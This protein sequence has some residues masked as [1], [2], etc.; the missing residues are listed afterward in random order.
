MHRDRGTAAVA[1]AGWT[2]WN[3]L[4]AAAGK[5][6]CAYAVLVRGRGTDGRD[7]TGSRWCLYTPAALGQAAQGRAAKGKPG[8]NIVSRTELTERRSSSVGAGL[9]SSCLESH[10]VESCKAKPRCWD[11]ENDQV[12][13]FWQPGP[14][15][16]ASGPRTRLGGTTAF[17]RMLDSGRGRAR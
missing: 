8:M 2:T 12:R 3:C 10:G 16:R 17:D 14:A 9:L 4:L 15:P 7:V 13:K 5:E 11:R 6:G 1:I